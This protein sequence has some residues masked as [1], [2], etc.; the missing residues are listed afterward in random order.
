MRGCDA[1]HLQSRTAWHKQLAPSSFEEPLQADP[2]VLKIWD[3]SHGH[4]SQWRGLLA[5]VSRLCSAMAGCASR[6]QPRPRAWMLRRR[7]ERGVPAEEVLPAVLRSRNVRETM[8][9]TLAAW[10][11]VV[12]IAETFVNNQTGLNLLESVMATRLSWPLFANIE[13]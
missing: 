2:R 9:R 13:T 12:E 8:V 6:L 11:I 5:I 3:R 1:E 10:T 7:C 4:P